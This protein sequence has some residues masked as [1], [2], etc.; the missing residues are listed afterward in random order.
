MLHKA[1]DYSSKS[2]RDE[3][4]LLIHNFTYT[5]YCALCVWCQM[6]ISV[7]MCRYARTCHGNG[8]FTVLEHLA[9]CGC[10]FGFVCTKKC[11]DHL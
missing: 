2:T 3:M 1:V 7:E 11:G 10:S 8:C 9:F 5:V 6:L 4:K